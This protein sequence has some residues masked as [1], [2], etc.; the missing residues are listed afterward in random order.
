MCY[1]AVIFVNYSTDV[2]ECLDNNGN[3][4]HDCVNTEGSYYCKCPAGY[5]LQPNYHVCEGK[6]I[7]TFADDIITISLKL[8]YHKTW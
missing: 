1:Y 7:H 2:D 8:T 4:S 6:W 3:C 5:I